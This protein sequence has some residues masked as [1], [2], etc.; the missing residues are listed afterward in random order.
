MSNLDTS[1]ILPFD[2]DNFDPAAPQKPRPAVLGE[3]FAYDGRALTVE[4]FAAHVA[5]YRFGTIPP[6]FAVLHHTAKPDASW[7]P[8]NNDPSIKWDRDER[9]KSEAQIQAKRK[10]Q[11]DGIK[12]YY[13]GLGWNAGP[14][15]FIDDRFIWL[16]TPMY[17]VGIHAKSG[18]SYHD[19]AGKLKYSIGIEVVGYYEKVVWPLNVAH[20][21]GMA[22]AILRRRLGT[23]ALEYRPGPR[24]TPAAHLGSLSSHRDYNKPEC[25]GKAITEQFYVDVAQR[26]WR[27]LLTGGAG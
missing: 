13:A 26:A 8:L 11:L 21:V 23:F 3:G 5:A 25:P 15:L 16:F 9:G 24:N 18:N 22:L 20:N 17:D 12:N 19:R 10:K 27:E 2:N 6:E 7:A 4:E 1:P 14:H